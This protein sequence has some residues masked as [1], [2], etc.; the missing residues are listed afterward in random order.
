M[1][2][3]IPASSEQRAHVQAFNSVLG[4]DAENDH[5]KCTKPEESIFSAVSSFS[6]RIYGLAGTLLDGFADGLFNIMFRPGSRQDEA[7]RIRVG[8]DWS[9]AQELLHCQCGS[10]ASS[11]YF[12]GHVKHLQMAFSDVWC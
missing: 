4:H 11:V 5:H 10:A 8:R 12:V 9:S 3:M 1:T 2:R 7:A 6:L